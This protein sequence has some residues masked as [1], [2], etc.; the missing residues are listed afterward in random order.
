MS[1]GIDWTA[2]YNNCIFPLHSIKA[3]GWSSGFKRCLPAELE[4]LGSTP[5]QRTKIFLGPISPKFQSD[6][7][8]MDDKLIIAD[9]SIFW[10]FKFLKLF[11]NF[12]ASQ[13]QQIFR[14]KRHK[15]LLN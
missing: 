10:V 6:V 3:A 13:P 12:F 11:F 8:W 1:K 4:V 7:I 15:H 9:L 14:G 2:M 5:G